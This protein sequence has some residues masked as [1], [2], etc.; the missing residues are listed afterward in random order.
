[1]LP[2]LLPEITASELAQRIDSPSPPVIAE[3]L[4]SEYYSTGH[5]PGALNLPLQDFGETAVR[6]LPDKAAEIV[7]Y[8]ASV[9]CP[10]SGIAQRTLRALGYEN[11]RVFKGGKAAWKASGRPLVAA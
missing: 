5:L 8:C 11:V 1:M 7:V 6:L 4:G 10:N 3:I 2:N 9:T